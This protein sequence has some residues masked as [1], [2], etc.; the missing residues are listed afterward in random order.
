MSDRRHN[1]PQYLYIHHPQQPDARRNKERTPA[2]YAPY[3]H[4][5]AHLPPYGLALPQVPPYL[6]LHPFLQLARIDEVHQSASQTPFPAVIVSPHSLS[7]PPQRDSGRSAPKKPSAKTAQARPDTTDGH[8]ES[9]RSVPTS[10]PTMTSNGVSNTAS[11]REDAAPQTRS[12]RPSIVSQH[13]NSVPSTPL[14]VARKYSTRSRSPSPNGGLG[15]HS[16]RSVS[17]EANST[18]PTLRPARPFKCRFETNVGMLGRRRMPYQSDEILEKAKEEPKK[19]LD[20]HEDDKL[21]GDMR[22][23]YDRLEPK[24][25]DTDN[26]ERFVRKVQRILETEFPGTKIMVHV[27]GSSGNM[28]WT[29]ES[30]VDICIQTP[31]KRLE[32]M[33]PLAEALDKH[34]MQRVVCIPAAKVR[35]VKVWDPELQLSC[36][37]N[38]NNVAAIENT[39]MIKTYIQLDDRVR[40]LAMIIKHWTKRRIL[41]DAGKSFLLI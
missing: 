35:I 41:N 34:G 19:S 28:L 39:R 9:Q 21:S 24:Q 17:S 31:M 13:S 20:P 26:R 14:Q 16:P 38:V 36:D 33:H 18:M 29:S 25:E 30:D 7:P 23:L 27:F 37:I 8:K 11:K 4:Q 15:S 2:L 12:Q 1:I 40:P 6:L 5:P 3:A 22:E 32:E 10:A